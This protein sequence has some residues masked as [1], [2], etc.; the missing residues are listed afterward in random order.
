MGLYDSV[1]IKE[2]HIRVA[3]GITAAIAAVRKKYGAGAD[4]TGKQIEVEVTNI[5]EVEEA[6]AAG[7]EKI[8]LDN[9]TPGMV[10]D[11]IAK[12]DGKSKI[13][14]SG[15]INLSNIDNYLIKGVDYISVGALTHSV[16]AIDLSLEILEITAGTN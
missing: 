15:G 9:M 14:V 12:I 7:V 11:A 3:G 13:E 6:L 4:G 10:R 1:L 2:N 16:K 5:T 8:L